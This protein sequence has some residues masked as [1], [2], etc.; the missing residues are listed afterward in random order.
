MLPRLI[1]VLKLDI[2]TYEEI[3]HDSTAISQAAAIVGVVA[4]A[5]AIAQLGNPDFH[6]IATPLG[7]LIGAFIGWWIGSWVVFKVGTEL[8]KG[9]ADHGE[10]L[11]VMGF[12]QAPV[13]LAALTPIPMVGPFLALAGGI[14]ALV[15]GFIAIRQ[16]LDISNTQTVFTILAAGLVYLMVFVGIAMLAGMLLVSLGLAAGA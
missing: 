1:G 11:R 16:G 8:F 6:A 3:E 7:S 9:E 12:A 5:Q 14:W 13:M 2:A 4:L 10:M 15:T